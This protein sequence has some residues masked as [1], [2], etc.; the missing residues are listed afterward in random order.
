MTGY[1]GA[2]APLYLD[3]RSLLGSGAG[4]GNYRPQAASPLAGRGV[5]GNGDMDGDGAIRRVP[6][7]AGAYQAQAVALMPAGAR[8]ATRGAGSGVQLALALAPGSARVAVLSGASVL[9]WRADLVPAAARHG[10]RAREAALAPGTV[11]AAAIL[12][13]RGGTA[14]A[15]WSAALLPAPAIVPQQAGAAA[16]ALAMALVPAAAALPLR[17]PAA[18]VMVDAVFAL[19]PASA[20]SG[21]RSTP[22]LLFTSTST[23]NAVLIVGSDPRILFP[24]RN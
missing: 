16:L 24:N 18:G 20:R 12:T 6:F 9:M 11:P 7:T 21:A 4:G 5:R 3:D 1:A 19:A 2:I 10:Q 13:T 22:G 14:I 17:S 23:A 15:G 8:S